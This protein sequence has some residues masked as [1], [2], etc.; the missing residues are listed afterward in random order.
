MGIVSRA[1]ERRYLGNQIILIYHM[2]WANLDNLCL[3]GPIAGT[4]VSSGRSLSACLE[5]Q[6]LASYRGVGSTRWSHGESGRP[7][8][9]PMDAFGWIS[10]R[11]QVLILWWVLRV[12]LWRGGNAAVEDPGN[13]PM[14]SVFGSFSDHLGSW[15]MGVIRCFRTLG[16]NLSWLIG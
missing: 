1:S 3:R 16:Y 11:T 8:A 2:I 10:E 9:D 14:L 15:W 13:H 4:R 6:E 7:F 12:C 5:W